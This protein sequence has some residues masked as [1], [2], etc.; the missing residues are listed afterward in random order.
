MYKWYLRKTGLD[1]LI[2]DLQW[3]NIKINQEIDMAWKRIWSTA[4]EVIVVLYTAKCGCRCNEGSN[5]M[6]IR[7]INC[8]V[9]RVQRYWQLEWD[10]YWHVTQMT[11]LYPSL[12]NTVCRPFFFLSSEIQLILRPINSKFQSLIPTVFNYFHSKPS[13]NS[14]QHLSYLPFILRVRS[15]WLEITCTLSD[16]SFMGP[17]MIDINGF[18]RT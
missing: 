8:E 15:W 7:C 9:N 18:F 5:K 4:W 12:Y 10:S 3:T 13:L 11:N 17:N 2:F 16:S 6:A 1:F 14:S